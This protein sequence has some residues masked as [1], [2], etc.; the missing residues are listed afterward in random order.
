[1]LPP[2]KCITDM[3][4]ILG[5]VEKIDQDAE[6][7]TFPIKIAWYLQAP[8]SRFKLIRERKDNT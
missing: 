4:L 8:V 6:H 3:N 7:P 1:M 5:E 2:E